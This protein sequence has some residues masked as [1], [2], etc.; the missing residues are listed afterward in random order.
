MDYTKSEIIVQLL[1]RR[2]KALPLTKEENSHLDR[3]L[4]ESQG[5]QTIFENLSD[6]QWIA[7][8]RASYYAPGKEEGLQQLRQQLFQEA[9]PKRYSLRVVFFIFIFLTAVAM[10]IL[11]TFL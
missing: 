11:C 8:A 3:W 9:S 6:E 1:Y 5:H 4:S 10:V 7:Q 2:L